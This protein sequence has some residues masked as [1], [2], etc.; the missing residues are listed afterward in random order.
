MYKAYKYPE[1]GTH[2]SGNTL[3]TGDLV[4]L[5]TQQCVEGI[6]P[7]LGTHNDSLETHWELGTW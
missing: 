7:E 3:D 6:Y 2:D 4:D 5:H 1:L